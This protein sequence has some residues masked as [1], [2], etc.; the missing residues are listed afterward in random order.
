[1]AGGDLGEGDALALWCTELPKLRLAALND[2]RVVRLE[3]VLARVRSGRSALAACQRYGLLN[4]ATPDDGHTRGGSTGADPFPQRG[5]GLVPPVG[6]GS[7]R[8]PRQRCPRE[9]ERD[10]QGR[11]PICA[12]FDEPMAPNA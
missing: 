2:G 4:P 7:Y 1:V 8:C 9:A 11:P 10:D 5:T 3:R 12:L 6:R